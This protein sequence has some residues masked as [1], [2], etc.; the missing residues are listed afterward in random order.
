MPGRWIVEIRSGA[1]S[2]IYFD[3]NPKSSPLIVTVTALFGYFSKI[4]TYHYLPDKS[5]TAVASALGINPFFAQEYIDAA[6]N[7]SPNK[8]AFIISCLREYDLKSKGVGNVSASDGDLL[9]ELIY[10]I[11]H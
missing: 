5:K 1:L 4:M 10:K 9:K 8:V 7:Y 11:L 2:H 6:R 3:K